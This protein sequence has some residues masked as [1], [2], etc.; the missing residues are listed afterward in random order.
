M[1]STTTRITLYSIAFGLFFPVIATIIEAYEREISFSFSALAQMHADHPLLLII[2]S[3]PFI[4][5]T[6]GYWIGKRQ[7]SL[8]RAKQVIHEDANR[9]FEMSIDFLAI[10]NNK[11]EILDVNPSFT[12][13]LG[14]SKTQLKTM[15]IIDLIH[16]ADR[17]LAESKLEKLLSGI[18]L[19]QLELRILTR[20][21]SVIWLSVSGSPAGNDRLFL[22]ARNITQ[23]KEHEKLIQESESRL[24]QFLEAVPIGIYVLRAGGVPFFANRMAIEL[25]GKGILPEK[26]T[27]Q[28]A[29]TYQAYKTGTGQLYPTEELPIVISLGGKESHIDDM[30]IRRDGK[31]IPIE[32]WA[33]PVRDTAGNIIFSVAAFNDISAWRMAEKKLSESEAFLEKVVEN[34]PN[35][36]FVKEASELRFVRFNKAGEELIGVP[37]ADL[38]GKNDFDFFPEEQAAFF[39]GKDREVFARGELIDIPEEPIDT[40]KKGKRFLHTKK[41]PIYDE[42]GKPRFLLGISDDITEL[43]E[44]REKVDRYV[45]QLEASN[46]SLDEFAHVVSHDLKAPLRAINNL[47]EWISEDLREGNKDEIDEHIR[48][49]R[50]RI[51]RMENLIS[52]ILTYSRIGR[53]NLEISEFDIRVLFEEVLELN[54]LSTNVSITYPSSGLTITGKR[55]RLQ[56]VFSNLLNNAIKFNDKSNPVIRIGWTSTA[57]HVLFTIADNGPGIPEEYRDRIFGIFQRLQSKDEIEGSGLGLSMVRKIVEHQG[58]KI[59]VSNDAELGGAR[60]EFSWGLNVRATVSS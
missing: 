39:T 41:V 31:S 49:M 5:G 13:A 15:R 24:H 11:G 36:I 7:Q 55:I 42:S 37:S 47:S 27:S 48:L 40:Q 60:F 29:E 19:H 17:E 25:L 21:K 2:D 51:K 30:E 12:G 54:S 53:E 4:L 23:Y 28:L 20:A 56:Q 10:L 50:S 35:M 32:V 1:N 22:I 33:R 6:F 16:E 45:V 9:F 34:I 58:G 52:G 43:K 59:E 38:M 8:I 3:A 18:S 44:T 57:K 14:L 46:R 26:T